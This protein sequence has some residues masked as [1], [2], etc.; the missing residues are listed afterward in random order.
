[1]NNQNLRAVQPELELMSGQ[2]E[3]DVIELADIVRFLSRNRFTIIAVAVLVTALGTLYAMMKPEEYSYSTAIHIGS[4]DQKKI[5][6]PTT[7]TANIQNYEIPLAIDNFY[8]THPEDKKRYD[9]AVKNPKGSDIIFM[10]AKSTEKSSAVYIELI[11]A[12][13]KQVIDDLNRK[14]LAANRKVS[15]SLLNAEKR[16]STVETSLVEARRLFG[17]IDA[18]SKTASG[19]RVLAATNLFEQIQTLEKTEYD[20][21]ASI[22]SMKSSLAELEDTRLGFPVAKSVRPTGLDPKLIV[23][24]SVI[25]GVFLGLVFSAVKELSKTIRTTI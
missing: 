12:I 23:V 8:R 10:E 3:E 24:L 13:A 4:V 18:A 17:V 25:G 14:T 20:L 16:K 19:E 21:A 11:N 15:E 2:S 22:V 6:D 7:L 5:V 1:M 9:I